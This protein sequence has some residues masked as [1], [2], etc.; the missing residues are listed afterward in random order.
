MCCR[1]LAAAAVM[2]VSS[3]W[4]QG[5]SGLE[6]Q[7]VSPRPGAAYVNCRT[8]LGFRSSTR[9]IEESLKDIRIL[10]NGS[11]SGIQTGVLR[12]ARDQMTIICTPAS[13]FTPGEQVAVSVPAGI[14]TREGVGLKGMS[15]SFTISS[16]QEPVAQHRI[17]P[18]KPSTGRVMPGARV[19][20]ASVQPGRDPRTSG[21]PDDFPPISVLR[22]TVP[23]ADPVFIGNFSW[24]EEPTPSYIT[25]LYR[26][27]S[28][29]FYKKIYGWDF[30]QQPSGL[31]TYYDEISEVFYGMDS[32]YQVVD[33]FY[34]PIRSWIR[35]TAATGIPR[36]S[37]S[38]KSCLMAGRG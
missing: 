17:L 31:L 22:N 3:A 32:A 14:R 4:S 7:Y 34:A 38:C 16:L 1:V 30:K 21:L 11:K 27:G 10:L 29:A 8:T 6:F 36:T 35:S 15:Y 24:S 26:D 37:M 23:G 18:P 25:I 12:L 2:W 19:S 33:S 13:P 28:P 9:I 5:T 20:A